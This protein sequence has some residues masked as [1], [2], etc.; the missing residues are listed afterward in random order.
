ML[1]EKIPEDAGCQPKPTTVLGG[2][3]SVAQIAERLRVEL[4]LDRTPS[5]VAVTAFLN[6]LKVPFARLLGSRI[7]DP[8]QVIRAV[9]QHEEAVDRRALD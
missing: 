7:Y 2:R 6:R 8:N 3:L 4:G 9:R 5:V 1:S